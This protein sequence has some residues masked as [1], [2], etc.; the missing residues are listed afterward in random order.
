MTLKR[1]IVLFLYAVLTMAVLTIGW[2]FWDVDA[3]KDVIYV[4][5]DDESPIALVGGYG[6]RIYLSYGTIYA[7]RDDP[8][9][10]Y[11]IVNYV[12]HVTSER[13]KELIFFDT[14]EEAEAA[15]FKPSEHFAEDYACWQEEKNDWECR[16]GLWYS[17]STPDNSE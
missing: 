3:D 10:E 7:L 2:F 8:D 6:E 5:T 9:K 17:S 14:P 1:F 15:G 4:N 12:I 11:N 13:Y 16:G